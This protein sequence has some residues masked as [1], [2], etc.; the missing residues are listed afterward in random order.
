MRATAPSSL[1]L[2]AEGTIDWA[3]FGLYAVSDLNRKKDGPA[4]ITVA[5]VGTPGQ[6][7]SYAIN[8]SWSDGA[9]TLSATTSS[10]IYVRGVGNGFGVTV[11]AVETPQTLRI[12]VSNYMGTANLIAHLDG[13]TD[14]TDSQ[15]TSN[16][17]LLRYTFTFQAPAGRSLSVTWLVS[18]DQGS[19]SADLLAATLY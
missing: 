13:A 2:T 5:P 10:G 16:D 14:Y 6:Y 18:D 17:Q 15:T 3:H 11:P 1:D 8:F 12:Y 7:G 19:A 9:P 4:A